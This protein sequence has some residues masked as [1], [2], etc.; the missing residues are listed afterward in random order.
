MNNISSINGS[1][2]TYRIDNDTLSRA[3]LTFCIDGADAIMYTLVIGSVNTGS[4]VEALHLICESIS[5]S[6]GK[7]KNKQLELNLQNSCCQDDFHIDGSLE[8]QTKSNLDDLENNGKI[9]N[10]IKNHSKVSVLEEYFL[11]GLKIWGSNNDDNKIAINNFDIL[12]RSI[13]KW[14]LRLK[15]LPSWDSNQLKRW[16][17]SNG[18]QWIISPNSKYWPKQLQDLATQCQVAPPLCLWGIG[19]PNALI[20][21][22]QPLAIVGS[23]G[24]NDYGYELSFTFAKSCAKKGHTVI[25]GGAYGIDAAAHWG[26]L[27]ALDSHVANVNP[28][29]KTIV[30]FAGGLNKM[31]PSSN[32]QLFDAI[33]SSGGACISELCPDTTPVA[34]RFLL[35][36]RLI[37]AIASKVIVSQARLRSG[38][39][40]TANWAN[41]LNREIYSVPGDVTSPSNA[42]CNMLIHDGKAMMIC[43]QNDIDSIY[44]NSHHYL[45][46][47]LSNNNIIPDTCNDFQK[48]V[49]KAIQECKSKKICANI[50]NI[51]AIMLHTNSNNDFSISKISGEI[52]ILELNGIVKNQNGVFSLNRKNLK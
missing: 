9:L 5:E 16:F 37:A 42:G 25:S 36:N 47:S 10:I 23:R 50:D 38:A 24:C 35:R 6:I 39:L 30:V 17:S 40:N 41:S 15:Q 2:N 26:T 7:T 32:A 52:A 14:C 49:L 3:I 11:K 45:P 1:N 13:K 44:P 31:G 12:H 20:Q 29:G 46:H 33:L 4:I 51:H 43:S 21:C 28:V 34:R 8:N 48:I 18:T 19:D 22:K 27:D